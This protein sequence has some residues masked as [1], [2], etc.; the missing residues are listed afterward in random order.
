MLKRIRDLL[1]FGTRSRELEDAAPL[2]TAPASTEPIVPPVPPPVHL[3]PRVVHQ[4]I[5]ED[6]LDADA[7]KIVR[8]LARFDHTAYLVGGCVRDLLVGRKPK[9]FD[10]ATTATPRQVRRAFSNCRIIG[11]RFRLAHVYFQN[12]KVIE[13]ATFRARDMRDPEEFVENGANGE[14]ADA[15]LLIRD[16]NVFGTPEEDAL[17][18][19]FT[20]N[21]LF[22]DV[23]SGNV[24]DHA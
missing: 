8:R 16:D 19:D 18:R 9:D 22:Y 10:I 24:I 15:D 12:G 21:A 2:V 6:D 1:S 14:D 11:R 20:I 3:G 4:P 13:V 7:V 23:N 5:P 17:R